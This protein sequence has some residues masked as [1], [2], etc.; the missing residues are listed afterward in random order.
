MLV[1]NGSGWAQ[2]TQ[3]GDLGMVVLHTGQADGDTVAEADSF[4]AGKQ[5]A[6][7]NLMSSKLKKI[8]QMAMANVP[9]GQTPILRCDEVGSQTPRIHF[10]I[11][12]AE[13]R[14]VQGRFI[15]REYLRKPISM[16]IQWGPQNS[17]TAKLRLL[18]EDEKYTSDEIYGLE[19][20]GGAGLLTNPSSFLM[21][22]R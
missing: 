8:V 14:M 10:S 16:V 5:C 13:A 20:E 3:L 15:K 17:V 12:P 4:V 19:F 18:G 11:T 9:K 22:G 21:R 1:A 2:F 7:L 6:D